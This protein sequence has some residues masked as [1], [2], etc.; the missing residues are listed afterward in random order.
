ML[1]YFLAVRKPKRL[2]QSGTK[3][4]APEGYEQEDQNPYDRPDSC[5][6]PS[7]LN[8]CLYENTIRTI[9]NDPD[10]WDNL[11]CLDKIE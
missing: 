10:D 6:R 5:D 8:E 7:R 9:A 2:A 4:I 11:D 1:P 3:R